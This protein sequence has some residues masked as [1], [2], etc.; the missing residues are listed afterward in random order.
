MRFRKLRFAWS[1][2]CDIACVLLIALWVR[3]YWWTDAFDLQVA[4]SH[5]LYLRSA[6]GCCTLFTGY[7]IASER[8]APGFWQLR[9][10][11]IDPKIRYWSWLAF[12]YDSYW[13]NLYLVLVIPHWLLALASA[14][15]GAVPW[16]RWHFS[17]RTLL[18]ATTLVA[19][20]LG[21]VVW[22]IR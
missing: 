1:V 15:L 17:L 4:T 2:A 6:P 12:S 16:I 9:H 5:P 13:D 18:I 10:N 3:S 8:H 11:Y 14:A 22:S 19:V 7:D 21:L 20:V